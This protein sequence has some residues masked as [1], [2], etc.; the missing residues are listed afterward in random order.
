MTW[1]GTK[2]LQLKRWGRR[3]RFVN[4]IHDMTRR[5]GFGEHR[6]ATRSANYMFGA[7]A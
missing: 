4:R 6:F 1:R 3:S 2:T 7:R 5:P